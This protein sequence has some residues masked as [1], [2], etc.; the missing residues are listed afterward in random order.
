MQNAVVLALITAGVAFILALSPIGRLMEEE[1]GLSWLFSL[2]GALP[3]PA[4]VAIVTLDRQSARRLD[5]PPQVRLWPRSL[6]AQMIDDLSRR[7]ASAIAIDLTLETPTD[8]VQDGALSSGHRRRRSVVLV[9]AMELEVLPV[10]DANGNPAGQIAILKSLPPIEP[11]AKAAIALAPFPLP[12]TSARTSEFWAFKE[13]AGDRLTLPAAA[14]QI[15]AAPVHTLW[16]SRLREA[17]VPGLEGL[18]PDNNL[19]TEAGAVQRASLAVR[20]AF[21]HD[22]GLEGRLPPW[23]AQLGDRDR[24]LVDALDRLHRGPQ[25]YHL[26]FYGPPGTVTTIPFADVIQG[27]DLPDLTGRAVFVEVAERGPSNLDTFY[28][29]VST[30]DGVDMSGI[31]IAATAFGNLLE[32]TSLKVPEQPAEF[33]MLVEFGIVIGLLAYLLPGTLSVMA[34]ALLATGWLAMASILFN[35][36]QLWLPVAVPLLVQVPIALFGGLLWQYLTANRE[37]RNVSQAIRYASA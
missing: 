23:P 1:F 15:H 14:L 31:E 13:G 3:P 4:D 21:L 16:M 17:G 6:R 18:L 32:G 33:G 8:Q 9:E 11:F 37:R 29:V 30:S 25:H 2:R 5:L 27:R 36:S 26:N 20:H 12:R 34:T 35:Q 7:G 10:T 22:P 24:R 28:T 19:L